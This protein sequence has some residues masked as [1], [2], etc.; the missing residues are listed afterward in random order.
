MRR[1]LSYMLALGLTGALATS[2]RA[3][4]SVRGEYVE[5]RTAEVFTGGC[6]MGSEAETMGK[7]AVLAWK[8]AQG[9][10]GGVSIDG[11]SVVAA[12]AGDR[13]LGIRELGGIAPT[14][15][16]AVVFVDERATS[17]QRE[18]L[19]AFA[20]AATRGLTDT[21]VNITAVPI[22][23]ASDGHLVQ[24]KAGE[25]TLRVQAHAAHA[26]NCGGMQ[27]F[28]PLA[29]GARAEVGHT[30]SQVY[31]GETLGTKWRQYDRLSAFV[32]TFDYR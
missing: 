32:G 21:I 26:P 11:L 22:E 2:A 14:E 20:R 18:A 9:Q 28:H 15:V 19:A 29:R 30:L 27:W 25:A 31:W 3:A 8:I 23:F 24:V 4:D 10:F 6:I 5:A 13:N 12:L 7:Q 16:R 17:A 1:Q